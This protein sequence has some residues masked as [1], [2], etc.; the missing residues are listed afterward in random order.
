MAGGASFGGGGGGGSFGAGESGALSSIP[1][2]GDNFTTIASLGRYFYNLYEHPTQVFI[3][4]PFQG[5]EDLVIEG[6]P[7]A[8][9]TIDA[10]LRL[11]ESHNPVVKQFGRALATLEQGGI[12][13]SSSDPFARAQLNK[14]FHDAVEGLAAQGVPPATARRELVNVINS[15]TGTPGTAISAPKVSAPQQMDFFTTPRTAGSDFMNQ[16][17]PTPFLPN[18]LAPQPAT[19][20][21]TNIPIRPRVLD[22][23]RPLIPGADELRALTGYD[24]FGQPDNPVPAVPPPPPPP[25]PGQPP[26]IIDPRECQTCNPEQYRDFQRLK[27]QQ[28]Q[29]QDELQVEKGQQGQKTLDQQDEQVQ[30]YRDL[31][32]QPSTQRD[33]P[34]E[35]QQKMNLLQQVGQ[36]LSDL[37][38][39]LDN[40]QGVPG[41]P[42]TGGGPQAVGNQQAQTANPPSGPQSIV[43]P[44]TSPNSDEGQLSSTEHQDEESELFY[45]QHPTGEGDPSQAVKFCVGCVTQLDAQ[46]F[47][48]G[49]PSACSVMGYPS[50][51]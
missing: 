38:Q 51:D 1:S 40:P 45:Q 47:L 8:Q 2:T 50:G 16:F 44:D 11:G 18:P 19:I 27:G 5:F 49:E 17:T 35:I 37:Q 26:Q 48:N 24:I 29:L 4:N 32:Q 34:R 28:G 22:L 30:H 31:E 9:D 23:I 42:V 13:L 6:K 36:E 12:V 14:I 46:K 33:I 25:Q 21:F 41:R 43:Q 7:R 39:A 15:G 20:P 10:V 3:T